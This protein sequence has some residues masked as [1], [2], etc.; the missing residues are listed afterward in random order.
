M[1]VRT[2][3]KTVTFAKP[4]LLDESGDLLPAGSY[5][6]ETDEALVE[7]LSF[8]VYRRVL[9]VISPLGKPGESLL[10]KALTVDPE[11]LDA[12]LQRD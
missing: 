9:T 12:A 2:T 5:V 1:T 3:R 8:P 7:G 4:F 6:V 11:Q 10:T